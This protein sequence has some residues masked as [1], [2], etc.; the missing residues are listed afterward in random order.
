LKKIE[1]KIEKK[2]DSKLLQHIFRHFRKKAIHSQKPLTLK[3]FL[4]AK[5]QFR[6]KLI[7]IFSK[8]NDINNYLV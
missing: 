3:K 6:K 2:I 5:T 4:R 1:K 8:L 7:Y